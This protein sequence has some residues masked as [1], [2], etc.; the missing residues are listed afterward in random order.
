MK[1]IAKYTLKDDGREI[2]MLYLPNG[3][4]ITSKTNRRR[5]PF[6]Y[7]AGT[8]ILS[9]EVDPQPEWDYSNKGKRHGR[10]DWNQ[11][12]EKEIHFGKSPLTQG[13]IA[14][15]CEEWIKDTHKGAMTFKEY[16]NECKNLD[17][18][19]LRNYL[20]SVN[21]IKP[22]ETM[23]THLGQKVKVLG[24]VWVELEKTIVDHGPSLRGQVMSEGKQW[25]FNYIVK[26]VDS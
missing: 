11:T 16:S 8:K 14:L 1:R 12:I 22:S 3:P 15:L 13:D 26:E 6:T 7:G 19:D 18:N 5:N 24:G 23:P 25:V 17:F 2:Q 20:K 21:L 9:V 4:F 10:A